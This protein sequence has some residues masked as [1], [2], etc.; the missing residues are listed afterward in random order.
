MNKRTRILM[1]LT[2]FAVAFVLLFSLALLALEADHDCS[3]EDC[4]ICCCI[5]NCEN[6][7]RQ[8]AG[9]LTV[10]VA[11]AVF[12]DFLSIACD[13]LAKKMIACTPITLKDKLSN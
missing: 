7:L 12:L 2:A 13:N 11:I 4:Q 5:Q 9:A 1:V 3:G 6:L 10:S 8:L